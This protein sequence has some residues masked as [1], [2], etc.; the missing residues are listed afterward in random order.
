MFTRK[1][2]LTTLKKLSNLDSLHKL[3]CW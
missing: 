3:L 1:K 2:D